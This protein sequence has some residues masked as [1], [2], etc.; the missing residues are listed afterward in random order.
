M[1]TITYYMGSYW[2]SRALTSAAIPPI[3][4]KHGWSII[5]H[6]SVCVFLCRDR[7]N[8][9]TELVVFTV[10][11]NQHRYTGMCVCFSVDIDNNGVCTAVGFVM[12]IWTQYN[13]H[14]SYMLYTHTH[15][16]IQPSSSKSLNMFSI[17]EPTKTTDVVKKSMSTISANATKISYGKYIGELQ[18]SM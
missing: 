5:S 4:L 6:N 2:R 10:L 11:K 18:M 16:H 3:S 13:A 1:D 9:V 8:F 14:I 12:H 15:T 17:I 7:D